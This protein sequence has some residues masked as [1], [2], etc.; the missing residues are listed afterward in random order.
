MKEHHLKLNVL[1]NSQAFLIEAVSKAIV[2]ENDARNW[3]F[4]ILN[5]VQSLELSLKSILAKST[6]FSYTRI[7]IILSIPLVLRKLLSV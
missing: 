1:E 3:Q 6:L 4:A 2:A 7:L 5:L